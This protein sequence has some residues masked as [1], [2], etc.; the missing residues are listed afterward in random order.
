MMSA[1]ARRL[2]SIRSESPWVS[3]Q[4]FVGSCEGEIIAGVRTEVT[5]VC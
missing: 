3:Q 4:E 5:A 2:D 1:A